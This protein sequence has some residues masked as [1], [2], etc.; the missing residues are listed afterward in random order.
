VDDIK[1]PEMSL[2]VD[3]DT[4]SAHVSAAG[5]HDHVSGLELDMVDDLVLDKVK[6][7]GVVDLDGRV[8]V[9]NRSAVVGDNVRDALGAELVSSDLQQLE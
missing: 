4:G 3:D 6:L 9:S 1:A 5:D 2:P 7:D 8:G